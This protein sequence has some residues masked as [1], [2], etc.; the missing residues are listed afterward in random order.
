MWSAVDLAVWPQMQSLC[1]DLITSILHVMPQAASPEAGVKQAGGSSPPAHLP[2]AP[3][4]S[5]IA[6]LH[7]GTATLGRN[8]IQQLYP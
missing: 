3:S 5:S 8:C 1:T 7:P 6:C 4:I 2:K